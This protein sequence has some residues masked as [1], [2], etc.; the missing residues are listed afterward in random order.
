MN[1]SVLCTWNGKTLNY[2]ATAT[3]LANEQGG[4]REEFLFPGEHDGDKNL[5]V[6]RRAS[7][8]RQGDEAFREN[9]VFC[10][11]HTWNGTNLVKQ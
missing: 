1:G 4:S 2:G 3:S 8:T 10:S 9:S 5:V 6:L 11:S 7:Q